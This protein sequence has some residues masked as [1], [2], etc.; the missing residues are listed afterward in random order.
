MYVCV[1]IHTHTYIYIKKTSV[2]KI[3][4]RGESNLSNHSIF[5]NGEK[6]SNED[7]TVGMQSLNALWSDL[8][9]APV[10]VHRNGKLKA[11]HYY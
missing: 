5:H 2:G 10:P 3:S 7:S 8:S 11:L 1:Y 6:L 9:F 4:H